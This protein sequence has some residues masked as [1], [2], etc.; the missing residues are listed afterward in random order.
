MKEI[1]NL[2][3]ESKLLNRLPRSGYA[4]LG[5]G[6]ESVAEHSF[7]I[8]FIAWIMAQLDDDVD[9]LHLV[10]LCLLHDLPEARIGDLNY[11]Q[12]NYVQ[13]DERRALADATRGLAFGDKMAD[14]VEEFNSG[15]SPEAR[16]ARDA[17]Q[18]A[19]ILDL[20]EI[21]D[22]GH[23][24]AGRWIDNAVKRLHT[25]LGKTLA[26][27]ILDTERDDWWFDKAAAKL[28]ADKN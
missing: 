3:F 13:A 16:L 20:K 27:A 21:L 12:R 5:A 23:L 6:K 26:E 11:V 1:A 25:P 18:L 14:L 9:S 15:T 4:F 2:L 19:L 24:P 22:N 7:S 10:S 28:R 17:D 8:T